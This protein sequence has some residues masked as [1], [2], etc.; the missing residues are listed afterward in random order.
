M[1]F[2]DHVLPHGPI[3]MHGPDLWTVTG[4]LTNLPLPRTMVVW[5]HSEGLWLHSSVA[6]DEDTLEE[7]LSLG[8]ITH[9]VVP[10]GFHRLDGGAYGARFP[11]AQVLCPQRV[12]D[13]VES[14]VPVDASCEEVLPL[15]GIEVEHPG[16]TH[17]VE[18]AYRVPF[19][20]GYALVVCDLLFNIPERLPGFKGW[21]LEKIGSTGFFGVTGIGRAAIVKSRA[22][23]A[24]WLRLEA[25]RPD[26][27]AVFPAHGD[28]VLQGAQEA[29]RQAAERLSP[30]R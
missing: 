11:E 12:R 27:R 15:L 7:L 23:V 26:L 25:D 16:G 3:T 18:L 30:T 4:S 2:A 5:R 17:P 13:K 28:P 10:S 6:V 24:D 21:V 19:D 14:A 29:L 22:E 8:P 9:V 20:G 1:A